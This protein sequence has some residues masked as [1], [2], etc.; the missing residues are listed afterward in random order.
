MDN[1]FHSGARNT[2]E[3][4]ALC[5]D[6]NRASTGNM[7]TNGLTLNGGLYEPYQMKRMIHGIHGNSK[8]LYPF[9]HANKVVGAF[10]NPANPSR[11]PSASNR[12]GQ[13]CG[14]LRC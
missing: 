12:A 14:E 11:R 4:C 9:T 7:M 6:A 5:H 3:S 1:A 8:R 10:C 2:V 13:W